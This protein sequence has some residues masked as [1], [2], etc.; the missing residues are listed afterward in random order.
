VREIAA[1]CD[2]SEATFFNYFP[3]KDAVLSAWV[4]GLVAGAF[5]AG[6]GPI[7]RGTRPALR[8]ICSGLAEAIESDRDFAT[9]AWARTRMSGGAPPEHVIRLLSAGQEAGQLRRDLSA[10]QMGEILY[11]SICVTVASWLERGAPA[12][13]LGSELR[14][15][16]DLVLDGARRRNERVRPPA[17]AP[18]APPPASTR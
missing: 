10:R 11:A 6:A 17:K 1:V 4:H 9:R 18:L 14:R 15:G 5:E 16:S 7:D 13:S 3:T 12:G 8:G 2:I